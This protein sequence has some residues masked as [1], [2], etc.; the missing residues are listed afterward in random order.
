MLDH[1]AIGGIPTVTISPEL[2][3]AI[4]VAGHVLIV[5]ET[6]PDGAT[7]TPPPRLGL[8]DFFGLRRCL[9]SHGLSFTLASASGEEEFLERMVG[10]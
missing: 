8:P 6:G 5:A 10:G 1:P 2:Y 9:L 3:Q 4:L 7:C